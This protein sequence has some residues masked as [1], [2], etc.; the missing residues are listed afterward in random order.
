VH[1]LSVLKKIKEQPA[2]FGKELAILG[3]Q[4][5]IIHNLKQCFCATSFRVRFSTGSLLIIFLL[6]LEQWPSSGSS[7]GVQPNLLQ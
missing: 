6:C 7:L 3:G 2:S 5:E 1:I 4:L